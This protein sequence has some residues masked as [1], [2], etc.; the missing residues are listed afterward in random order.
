MVFAVSVLA[1]ASSEL[2]GATLKELGSTVEVAA[3]LETGVAD[4]EDAADVGFVRVEAALAAVLLL[5]FSKL[6]QYSATVAR[7]TWRELR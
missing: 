1:A 7:H 4:A 3:S 5:S 6:A 2:G